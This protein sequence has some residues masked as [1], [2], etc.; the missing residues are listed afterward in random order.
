MGDRST[1][2]RL[3]SGPEDWTIGPEEEAEGVYSVGIKNVFFLAVRLPYL[4]HMYQ[5]DNP[6]IVNGLNLQ[7]LPNQDSP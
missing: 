3:Q 1:F 6:K 2:R 7:L 5:E 4:C